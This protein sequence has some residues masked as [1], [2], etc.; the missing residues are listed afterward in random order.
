MSPISSTS[1][2]AANCPRCLLSPRLARVV[3]IALFVALLVLPLAAGGAG[4]PG[5]ATA[6]CQLGDLRPLLIPTAGL[7]PALKTD[8]DL[9]VERPVA[10]SLTAAAREAKISRLA[11]L[12]REVV[13]LEAEL[14][15]DDARL[16]AEVLAEAVAARR[17]GANGE[18]RTAP[19]PREDSG[20]GRRDDVRSKPAPARGR[21]AAEAH[22]GSST[23]S[24]Y[25]ASTVLAAVV[26]VLGGAVWW[27]LK[28]QPSALVGEVEQE[29]G[30]RAEQRLPAGCPVR[31][32]GLARA[33]QTNGKNGAIVGF[34]VSRGRYEVALEGGDRVSLRPENLAVR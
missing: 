17:I 7:R 31:V 33:T 28:Q 12:R 34:I 30:N 23:G 14:L 4:R 5:A 22:G 9:E 8:D 2:Q 10:S 13:Q 21:E 29:V 20:A 26:A 27:R 15:E 32:Q 16:E 19:S 1:A 3:E 6:P 25:Y 11:A 24:D 18:D